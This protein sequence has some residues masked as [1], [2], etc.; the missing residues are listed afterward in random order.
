MLETTGAESVMAIVS[1]AQPVKY[2]ARI[3]LVVG[4][5]SVALG[6]ASCR[7]VTGGGLDETTDAVGLAVNQKALRAIFL[8]GL[9]FAVGL[10][11]HGKV[12]GTQSGW[13]L[14]GD[15][16]LLNAHFCRRCGRAFPRPECRRSQLFGIVPQLSCPC[17]GAF[18]EQSGVRIALV[19]MV[20]LS[21][22][23]MPLLDLVF[24]HV[25]EFLVALGVLSF[26]AGIPVFAVGLL[27][28]ARQPKDIPVYGS[29]HTSETRV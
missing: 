17:C 9:G 4:L 6:F 20:L 28:L 3:V 13:Q 24:P 14:R 22:Y 19:G 29:T 25:P 2:L 16:V 18:L 12:P 15:L 10:Y 7:R 5:L 26:L 8:G 21:A 1:R 23:F 27:R 11:L